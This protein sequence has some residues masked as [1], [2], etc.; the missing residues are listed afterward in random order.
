MDS[1]SEAD[2]TG[3]SEKK[4]HGQQGKGDAGTYES[5]AKYDTADLPSLGERLDFAD[6]LHD[7]NKLLEAIAEYA[8]IFDC[9]SAAPLPH[10][11]L[12][13]NLAGAKLADTLADVQRLEEAEVAYN[14]ILEVMK[15]DFVPDIEFMLAVRTKRA[16]ALRASGDLR[17]SEIEYRKLLSSYIAFHGED[18]AGTNTTRY[19]LAEVLKAGGNRAEAVAEVLVAT[20]NL[21]RAARNYAEGSAAESSSADIGHHDTL[22]TRLNPAQAIRGL[23]QLAKK[24]RGSRS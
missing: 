21:N 19:R 3:D 23:S 5:D 24:L 2:L 22:I 11:S 4:R 13:R 6:A 1:G 18:A 8:A 9:L 7:D 15:R 17:H 16:E 20:M 10:S 14:G 12:L